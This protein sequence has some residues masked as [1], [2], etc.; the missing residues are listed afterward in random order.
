MPMSEIVLTHFKWVE[1]RFF[2]LSPW[3]E[4]AAETPE[5]SHH[6]IKLWLVW[7]EQNGFLKTFAVDGSEEPVACII[8]RP[9]ESDK[10]DRYKQHYMD[11]I[12]EFDSNPDTLL[13]DFAYG[14]GHIKLLLK[15]MALSGLKNT[16]WC[17]S[18]TGKMWLKPIKSLKPM[19]QS[20]DEP[21]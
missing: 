5:I 16:V 4:Q 3:V 10:I 17:H 9:I 21:V 13:V 18:R 15:V 8:A 2:E 7:C 11:T 1:Q 12:F 20:D 19:S 14:P 6:I